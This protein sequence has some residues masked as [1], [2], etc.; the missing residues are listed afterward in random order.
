[1]ILLNDVAKKLDIARELIRKGAN[2]NV[3]D[4]ANKLRAVQMAVLKEGSIMLRI[5][6]LASP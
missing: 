3:L 1:V 2:P 5:L 4:R 6:P